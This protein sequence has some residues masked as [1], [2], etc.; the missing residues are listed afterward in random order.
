MG[1]CGALCGVSFD[2]R[3]D[4]GPAIVSWLRCEIS[5]IPSPSIHSLYTPPFHSL[6]LS[7]VFHSL[8]IASGLEGLLV[9]QFQIWKTIMRV[10]HLKYYCGWQ[11]WRR[12]SQWF[13]G[14]SCT[15]LQSTT[16]LQKQI[17]SFNCTQLRRY[18]PIGQCH[19][20]I[21][22]PSQI[23]NIHPKYQMYHL[24]YQMY[25]PIYQLDKYGSSTLHNVAPI[26]HWTNQMPL[27]FMCLLQQFAN[28]FI[29]L[30]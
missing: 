9:A 24:Q 11:Y 18:P 25:L 6:V 29:S 30:D 4:R 8:S 23:S 26:E 14:K 17:A 15:Q 21:N 19:G 27:D 16:D 2:C 3:I 7:P 12:W 22:T 10:L 20:C 13:E 5:D 28:A 1:H